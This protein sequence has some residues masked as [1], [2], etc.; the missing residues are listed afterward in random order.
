MLL[1][2]LL[3][4]YNLQE[5]KCWLPCEMHRVNTP[6]ISS[7]Q[8]I[9]SSCTNTAYPALCFSTLSTYANKIQTSKRLLANTALAV[10]HNTTQSTSS[11]MINVLLKSKPSGRRDLAA[12]KDCV[13]V[14][15][16]TEEMLR[17]SME[18][19][20]RVVGSSG[21]DFRFKMSNVQTWLSGALTDE[22]TCVE[23]FEEGATKNSGAG[24]VGGD[25]SGEIVK[26]SQL[27]SNA[28]GL[29]NS[30]A[31]STMR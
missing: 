25:V 11:T 19:M 9:K 22:E 20:G 23:G 29:V 2:N 6:S 26:V 13:E 31:R 17:N 21:P 30:F 14:L 15:R 1:R 27:T 3:V 10:A 16:D 7:T 4:E 8:F 18:E 24:G 12:L 5:R 28:L